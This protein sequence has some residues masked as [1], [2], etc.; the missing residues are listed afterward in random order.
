MVDCSHAN[1]GSDCTRQGVVWRDVMGQRL[2]GQR[3]IRGLM[4]ESN[5]EAGKQSIPADLSQ[6]K[7]GVSV[8][9][10]CVGWDETAELLLGAAEGLRAGA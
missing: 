2:A 1:S 3:A 5:L 10:A 9:D 7:R 4:L 6:L 8:T